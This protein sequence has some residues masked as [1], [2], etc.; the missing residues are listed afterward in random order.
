MIT[1]IGDLV[2]D[3]LVHSD[4][5]HYGSDTES[6]ITT[7][8]GGQGNH[9]AAW[10]SACAGT[11]TL[12]GNVGKDV[13]GDYLLNE[14]KQQ[15]IHVAVNRT[16]QAETG[17]IAVFVDEENGERSMF[18]S[19]GANLTLSEQQ[20][21]E[22]E[23]LVASSDCLYISGYMLFKDPTYQ[24]VIRAKQLA[25]QY[26]V[27]VAVDPGSAYFLM[28]Y[29][30]RVLDFLEGANWV[31]PNYEEGQLLTGK[32]KPEDIITALRDIVTYPV[33]KLGHQGCMMFADEWIKLS[34]E[35]VKAVDTTGAGDSFLGGFLAH[36]YRTKN[37]KEA[38]QFAN[39]TAAMTVQTFGGRPEIP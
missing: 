28:E 10:I 14:A 12:I 22:H 38:L 26:N 8:A 5:F 1:V 31:F 7:R 16:E 2:V 30:D 32:E 37:A 9:V 39:Q 15:R 27:P 6:T 17:K 18:T 4:G 35:K 20:I 34:A 21:E 36:Y 13:F 29:K 11:A 3:I 33:L 23:S 24:A 19:R 25:R